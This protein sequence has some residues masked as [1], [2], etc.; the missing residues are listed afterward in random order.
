MSDDPIETLVL[1]FA[2]TDEFHE[3]QDELDIFDDAPD[4]ETERVEVQI[5]KRY[6]ALFRFLETKAAEAENR[7]ILPL[8]EVLSQTLVQQLE[9]IRIKLSLT[10]TS[11]PYYRRLW[12]R[13]C[14]EHGLPEEE[15]SDPPNS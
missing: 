14:D 9:A 7:P 8:S 4:G 5:P 6:L 10:R 3:L 13:L 11:H 15:V 2:D 1:T 12:N